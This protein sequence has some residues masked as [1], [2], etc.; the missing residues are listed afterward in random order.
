M[1]KN[2]TLLSLLTLFL[3]I[4]CK[5]NTEIKD[6]TYTFSME[7]VRA[8]KVEFQLNPDSTYQVRQYNYFFDNYEGKQRPNIKDGKLTAQEFDK[9]KNRLTK[10]YIEK[11]NDSYGFDKPNAENNIVY[12]VHLQHDGLDKFVSINE[13]T[14]GDFSADF[15]ELINFTSQFAN[16]KLE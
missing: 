15:V 1:T 5:K 4:G 6:F 11:M 16:S 8:F 9:F 13:N 12:M 10:S 3:F 14:M 2:I 7:S